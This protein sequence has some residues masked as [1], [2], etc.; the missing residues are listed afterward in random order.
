MLCRATGGSKPWSLHLQVVSGAQIGGSE[1]ADL[2]S[3]MVAA[4]NSKDIPTA[5]S[6]LE[7]FN[8][9]LVGR[10]RDGYA[11][12]LEAMTLPVTDEKLDMAATLAHT[13]AVTRCCLPKLLH[14][15]LH[16]EIFQRALSRSA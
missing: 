14:A 6:I 9:E 1:L 10:L 5:G 16:S 15:A 4:L 8:R 12:A 2:I 13:S 3:R 7:H 11:A